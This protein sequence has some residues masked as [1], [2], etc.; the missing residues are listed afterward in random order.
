MIKLESE[1]RE[2]RM[3]NS[4]TQSQKDMCG[5]DFPQTNMAQVRWRARWAKQIFLVF[6]KFGVSLKIH[7]AMSQNID[8]IINSHTSFESITLTQGKPVNPFNKKGRV[9]LVNFIFY[10]SAVSLSW[11]KEFSIHPA[12]DMG[13]KSPDGRHHPPQQ[14]LNLSFGFI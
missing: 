8:S 12:F 13:L 4:N 3:I 5:R 7:P 14:G 1:S 9:G 6:L 11:P 2:S 10:V